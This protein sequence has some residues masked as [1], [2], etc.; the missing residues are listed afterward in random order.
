MD[1]KL[2]YSCNDACVHC[3]VDDFRDVLRAQGMRQDRSTEEYRRLLQESRSRGDSVVFTGGEPTLRKDLADLL[4]FARDLG[5]QI[6]LQSNGRRFADGA[7]ADRLSGIGR[8]VYV[9]ALHGPEAAVHD[10]VTQRVG[11]YDETVRGIRNLVERRQ[12]ISGKIVISRLN[13]AVLPD[14][15]RR[16]SDLGVRAVSIAFPHALGRA[17]K[18]WDEVVPRYREVLP[19]LRAALDE[20]RARGMDGDA[21][22][23]TFCHMEG[24]ENFIGEIAQQL[25][26]YAEVHQYGDEAERRDW[27]KVRLE[28][29]RKFPQCAACRFDLVCEGPW[30]EYAEVCGGDEFVPVLGRRVRDVREIIDGSFRT[31][32]AWMDGLPRR[33]L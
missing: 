27:G 25:E 1:I 14:T 30:R 11:S 17:R 3:V 7:F 8:I 13:F 21:E 10:A 28:I 22:T 24:Y 31:P 6:Q 15:V 5:Y 33:L 32:A 9:I 4:E 23:F 19:H 26:P 16:L 29:K 12:T 2:G 20:V 18:M